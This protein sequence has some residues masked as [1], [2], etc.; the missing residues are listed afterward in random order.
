[1]I[2]ITSAGGKTGKAMIAAFAKS[3]EPV[4]ALMRRTDQDAQLT[5]VGASE[6]FHGDLADAADVA[7]AAAGCRAIYYI[8]PNM[9]ETEKDI[10]DNVI[11]AAKSAGVER[12]VFHSVLH[13]QVQALKHHWARL[14]VEEAIIESGVPFSILQVGSYYQN[15]LP[16]WA[17]ML[18]TGVHAMA[19][20]VEAPMS[21]VDL[22]DVSE[23]ALKVLNDPGCANGIFEFCGPV[24]TLTEK[25]EILTRI[26]GQNI[27]ARKLP[28]DQAVAHAAHMGVAE[29]GQDCMRRMFAHYDDHGLVGSP[30]VLEWI[31]GRPPT[32]FEAFAGRI[33]SAG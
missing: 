3:G 11:A 14:F 33:A 23:A 2:L 29:F 32:D 17:K 13:T 22:D 1:M 4:R 12:L 10:G 27:E 20:E 8:C 28:A 5:A 9:I 15:M 7:A 16:G 21:L 19:Y 31:L 26:L 6:I 24:I 30:R 25:A 18:E